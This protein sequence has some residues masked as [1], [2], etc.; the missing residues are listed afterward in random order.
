MGSKR[1]AQAE[2]LKRV[3]AEAPIGL[4]YFDTDLRYLHINEWLAAINGLEADK[5]LGRTL[6]EVLPHV[7]AGVESQLRHVIESGQALL[8]GTVGAE[9]AAHPGVIRQY[10]HN[11]YPVSSDDGTVVG[12]SCAVQDVTEGWLAQRNLQ[13]AQAQLERRVQDRTQSSSSMAILILPSC[14]NRRSAMF[15]SA[16]IFTREIIAD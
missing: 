12:V 13:E 3:Y 5:H 4:C 8:Q 6:G 7:A 2:D 9:T 1:I 16:I 10:A 14:G 11:Y 15:M